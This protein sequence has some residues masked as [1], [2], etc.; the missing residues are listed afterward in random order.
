VSRSFADFQYKQGDDKKPG[1]QKVSCVPE[2]YFNTLDAGDIVLLACDGIFDVMS[3]D[4]LVEMVLARIP[5][6]GPSPV[7]LGVI[8]ADVL[9]ECLKK[10]SKDNMTLII[11][12]VGTGFSEEPVP[13]EIQGVEKLETIEEEAVKT[14]Y[15]KFLEYCAECGTVPDD[16]RAILDA[17]KKAAPAAAKSHAAGLSTKERLQH[18]LQDRKAKENEGPPKD[19]PKAMGDVKMDMDDIDALAAFVAGDRDLP[20]YPPSSPSKKKNRKKKS[21]NKN[22][23][24]GAEA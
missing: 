5:Q 9:R 6:N 13:D 19:A 14:L 15:Y 23:P 21:P 1:E 2:L 10:D 16:V 12:E 22:S 20:A 11:A 7:D 24:G 17:Q 18:K 4:E 3:T 8:A